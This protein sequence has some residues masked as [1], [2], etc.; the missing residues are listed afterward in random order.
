MPLGPMKTCE[1]Q[2]RVHGP[3]IRD[4]NQPLEILRQPDCRWDSCQDDA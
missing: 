2:S 4:T 1:S 3:T